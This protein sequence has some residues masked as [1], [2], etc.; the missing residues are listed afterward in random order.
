LQTYIKHHEHHLCGPSGGPDVKKLPKKLKQALF[1]IEKIQSAFKMKDAS[2]TLEQKIKINIRYCWLKVDRKHINY[3]N[4]LIDEFIGCTEKSMH[5]EL[6]ALTSKFTKGLPY[7]VRDSSIF[8]N[9]E[10]G[11]HYKARIKDGRLRFMHEDLTHCDINYEVSTDGEKSVIYLFNDLKS[12]ETGRESDVI[13]QSLQGPLVGSKKPSQV[14]EDLSFSEEDGQVKIGVAKFNASGNLVIKIIRHEAP[15]EKNRGVGKTHLVKEMTWSR[16]DVAS[17][18]SNSLEAELGIVEER[19]PRVQSIF[20]NEIR[21]FSLENT[22]I[23]KKK[24]WI[25]HDNI[26]MQKREVIR[27]ICEDEE[28]INAEMIY[29]GQFNSKVKAHQSMVDRVAQGNNPV[30]DSRRFIAPEYTEYRDHEGSSESQQKNIFNVIEKLRDSKDIEISGLTET[31]LM[32]YE[33]TEKNRKIW[34][35]TRAEIVVK[36]KAADADC[37]TEQQINRLMK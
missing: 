33:P 35:K 3:V 28:N 23:Y 18:L 27:Q 37:S 2:K 36:K 26:K 19:Y 17:Y 1:E 25:C 32:G 9:D 7:E 30:G 22:M 31:I 16:V 10:N 11:N 13:I 6:A 12:L 24:M 5:G 15:A 14:E 4:D 34:E 8:V 20:E 21:N 29:I